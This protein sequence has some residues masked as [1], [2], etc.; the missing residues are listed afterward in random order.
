MLI[1][2]NS[3]DFYKCITTNEKGEQ[4]HRLYYSI[5]IITNIN[6]TSNAMGQT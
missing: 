3:D 4:C 1:S 6:Q 2:L 5:Q